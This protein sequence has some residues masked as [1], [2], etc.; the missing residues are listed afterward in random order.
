MSAADDAELSG[1]EMDALVAE[2]AR[3]AALN[4]RVERLGLQL[5]GGT[6]ADVYADGRRVRQRQIWP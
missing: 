1:A 2:C 4:D 3:F 6:R 5:R